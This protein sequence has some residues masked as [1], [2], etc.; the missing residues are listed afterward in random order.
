MNEGRLLK[1]F[2]GGGDK[3]VIKHRKRAHIQQAGEIL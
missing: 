2:L 3:V 1:P